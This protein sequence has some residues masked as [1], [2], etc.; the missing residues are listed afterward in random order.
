[1][2]ISNSEHPVIQAVPGVH[3]GPDTGQYSDVTK[4]HT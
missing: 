3:A 2:N 1:M 4:A